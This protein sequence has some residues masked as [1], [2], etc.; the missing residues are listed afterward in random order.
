MIEC[1]KKKAQERRATELLAEVLRAKETPAATREPL[2]GTSTEKASLPPPVTE[3]VDDMVMASSK[4]E[5]DP[6]KRH[7]SQDDV[8]Q[9]YIPK[10]GV[11]VSYAVAYLAPDTAKDIRRKSA[12]A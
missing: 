1:K 3:A 7:R 10:W 5:T 9:T 12:G 11:L 2:E 6:R 4:I 8:V